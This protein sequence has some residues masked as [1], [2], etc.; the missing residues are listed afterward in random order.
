MAKARILTPAARKD[1]IMKLI[2]DEVID[3]QEHLVSALKKR[4]FDVTQT[5]IS[6]DLLELGAYRGKGSKGESRYFLP[7][8]PIESG[9]RST[10]LLLSTTVSGNLVVIKTPP[11]GAQLLAS[12][13]DRSGIETLIGTI[14]GDDTVLA[15]ASTAQGGARLS[16]EIEDFLGASRVKSPVHSTTLK[17]SNSAK[18]K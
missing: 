17:K 2:A 9:A 8:L 1:T 18:R 4:G 6:R 10:N 5:T 14:A 3:S 13:L 7:S 11:G 16:R 12:S 15:I